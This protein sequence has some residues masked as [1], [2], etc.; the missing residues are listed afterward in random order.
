MNPL[1][2]QGHLPAFDRIQAEHV[3]A[4]VDQILIDTRQ[5]IEHLLQSGPPYSWENLLPPLELALQRLHQAWSPVSHLNAVVNSN[6]LREAYNACLPR[7]SAFETEL[8]Q[9]K[10]LYLA[11]KSVA[12]SP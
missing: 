2:E 11:V 7:L 9:H 1:L 8:G 6:A 5:R 10:A 4:A 3:E 12:E